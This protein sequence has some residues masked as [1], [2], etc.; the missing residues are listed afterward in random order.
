ML[1]FVFGPLVLCQR[2]HFS[3]HSPFPIVSLP[4]FGF[5]AGGDFNVTIV[6]PELRHSRLVI[7]RHSDPS[8]HYD[9]PLSAVPGICSAVPGKSQSRHIIDF[10]DS[11]PAT[12]SGTISESGVYSFFILNCQTRESTLR[13]EAEFKNP[14]TLLDSRDAAME[15]VYEALY[16]I[17]LGIFV[18][19]FLNGWIFSAFRVRLHTVFVLLPAI[20]FFQSLFVVRTWRARA[21]NGACGTFLASAE[22][23]LDI[24]DILYYTVYLSAMAFV[25]TGW[26]IF[27]QTIPRRTVVEI[28]MASLATTVGVIM[29]R[30]VDCILQFVVC[31]LVAGIGVIV[32]CKMIFVDVIIMGRLLEELK[33]TQLSMKISLARGYVV[34]NFVTTVLAAVLAGVMIS[35][36]TRILAVTI[37][38]ET[39]FLVGS[40]QQMMCFMFRKKYMGKET[41]K[42]ALPRA[43]A[44]KVAVLMVRE[45]SGKTVK[46]LRVM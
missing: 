34:R 2:H 41:G 40:I 9:V 20:R 14:T 38:F 23:E 12:I 36:Q 17:Y 3:F 13:V 42:D 25:G 10:G 24:L 19:W 29:V 44:D 31:I 16:W 5:D 11:M 8:S 7:A 15:T 43:R 39:M 30:R 4:P 21:V 22:I 26:C 35:L 45:P 32:Y 37:V 28:I 46:V 1:F 6:S 27:R 18:A 33:Q